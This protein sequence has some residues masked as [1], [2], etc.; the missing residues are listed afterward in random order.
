MRLQFVLW[1]LTVWISAHAQSGI[2]WSVP[3]TVA[4]SSF[5]N[6]HPRIALNRQGSPMVIWGR[7]SD[8]SVFFSRWDGKRFST[9]QKINGSLKIATASWMGPQIASYGDTVYVVMKQTPENSTESHI[10]IVRSEDGGLTFSSPQRVDAIADSISRFPTVT[11]DSRGNPIVGFMKFDARF[12]DSRWVVVTSSDLGRTFTLDRKASGWADAKGVCDCCPGAL[13]SDGDVVAMLYR[14]NA[15]DIRDIWMGVSNNNGASFVGGCNVD[16]N[17]WELPSCP[18]TGPDA[19]IVGDTLYTVFC[20]APEG[21]NRTFFSTSSTAMLEHH[22]T[23]RLPAGP[24]AA[25]QQNYPRIASKGAS[26]G[27]VWKQNVLGVTQLPILF[28]SDVS[29]GFPESS[30]IV[31]VEDITNAD[32]AVGHDVVAVCWE[33]PN[34]G[35]VG[36]RVGSFSSQSTGAVIDAGK[37]SVSVSPNPASDYVI[38]SAGASEVASVDMLNLFGQVLQS[39][40]I[41]EQTMSLDV[42]SIRP[43]VYYVRVMSGNRLEYRKIVIQH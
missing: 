33:D 8:E 21:F 41:A 22:Q 7:A 35:V 16:N 43:G 1:M 10:Y 27:I 38:V 19:V 12:R 39:Y 32:I 18:A 9:P 42:A 23:R 40:P 20:S 31:D 6:L 36:L 15:N 28:T 37:L 17:S 25:S 11:C 5:G 34:A 30:E 29:R 24:D 4:A 13:V 14:N 2:T 26:V 3:V